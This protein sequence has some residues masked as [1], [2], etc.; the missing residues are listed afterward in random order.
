MA[1]GK[2]VTEKKAKPTRSR[3]QAAEDAALD[4]VDIDTLAESL[5]DTGVIGPDGEIRPVQIGKRGR[6][7]QEMEH[8]FSLDDVDYFIPKNPNRLLLV[9]YLRKVAAA[10]RISDPVKSQA[11]QDAAT[12]DLLMQLLGE[13]AT[14]ALMTSPDTTDE[15]IA[16]VFTAVT[17]VA[18]GAVAKLRE[19]AQG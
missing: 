7:G 13:E 10:H 4:S 3:A 1:G 2:R 18:M 5:N 19:A 11:A 8:I 14:T 12:L 17:K 16:D 6:P 9:T 15:D